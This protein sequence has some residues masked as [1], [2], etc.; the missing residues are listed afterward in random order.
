MAKAKKANKAERIHAKQVA[1]KYR[2]AKRKYV[3]RKPAAVSPWAILTTLIEAYG[4][5]CRMH[6]MRYGGNPIDVE[7]IEL[8]LQLARTEVNARMAKMRAY[9]DNDDNGEL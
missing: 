8:R 3:R 1:D 5:A 9:Y 2:K 6:E 4:E 7:A